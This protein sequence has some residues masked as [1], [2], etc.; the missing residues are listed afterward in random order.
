MTVETEP[1]APRDPRRLTWDNETGIGRRDSFGGGI[2]AFAGVLATRIVKVKPY[3]P[4]SKRRGG[5]VH[6]GFNFPYGSVIMSPI[7][8]TPGHARPGYT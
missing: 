3:D 7:T 5:A 8:L 4:E 6:E 1:P 2:A